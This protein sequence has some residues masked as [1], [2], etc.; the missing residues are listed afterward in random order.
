MTVDVTDIVELTG[1]VLGDVLVAVVREDG[2]K[3]VAVKS[4]PLEPKSK[5]NRRSRERPEAVRLAVERVLS[6]SDAEARWLLVH[7]EL[8]HELDA[9]EVE[10]S[11]LELEAE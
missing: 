10:Q 1:G 3:H 9:H 7:D 2:A 4:L 5:S 11:H 8:R 6:A